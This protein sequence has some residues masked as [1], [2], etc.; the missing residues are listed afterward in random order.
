MSIET[1]IYAAVAAVVARTYP[2]GAPVNPT[3]PYSVYQLVGGNVVNF[4]ENTVPGLNH[5]DVTVEVWADTRLAANALMRAVEAAMRAATAFTA[6]PI[7]ALAGDYEESVP[8]Y[9]ARQD[10]SCWF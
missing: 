4:T 7:S 5:A 10:F 3:R 2:D 9:G 1:D 8:E 6:Q